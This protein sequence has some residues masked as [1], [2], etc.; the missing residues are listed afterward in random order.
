MLKKIAFSLVVLA[1]VI[2]LLMIGFGKANAD[3]PDP[4]QIKTSTVVIELT[5]DFPS[6]VGVF[7]IAPG[8]EIVEYRI[9]KLEATG[10]VG[11]SSEWSFS[12]PV[13]GSSGCFNGSPYT[14]G[15]GEQY[16]AGG[17][18]TTLFVVG[19]LMNTTYEKVEI[20]IVFHGAIGEPTCE[21]SVATN[22][23]AATAEVTWKGAWPLYPP[24]LFWGDD[25]AKVFSGSEGTQTVEHEYLTE[26]TYDI[27]FHVSGPN[28][29]VGCLAIVIV[30]SN[31]PPPTQPTPM[32]PLPAPG[33]DQFTEIM[34]TA[35]MGTFITEAALYWAPGQVTDPL[36]T[37]TAGKTYRIDGLDE[38]GQ[39]RQVLIGCQWL[40]VETTTVTG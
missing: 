13:G 37:I 34:P 39:Y 28:G 2:L 14:C 3:G 18:E 5:A 31:D 16:I 20:T 22:G 35:V 6:G 21:L 38:S 11:Q 12:Q 8:T 40:W 33:C 30:P 23:M 19:T 29:Y 17:P 9:T 1:I 32:I 7:P 4:V 36:V 15:D 24:R 26:G 10:G 25:A 27:S